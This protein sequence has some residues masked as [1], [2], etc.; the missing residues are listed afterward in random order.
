MA[1]E[2]YLEKKQYMHEV[3]VSICG[4]FAALANLSST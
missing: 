1:A 4:L 3:P 2:E